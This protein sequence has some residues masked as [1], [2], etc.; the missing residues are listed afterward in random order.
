MRFTELPLAGAYLIEVEPRGDERGFFARV[1]CAR[2]FAAH[3]LS[4][5]WSQSNTSFSA[6]MGTVRGMH[7]QRPPHGEVKLVRCT[8]GAIF[9]AIVDMR[10]GSPTYGRWY[11]VRLDAE[12]RNMLYVPVGFAHGFQTLC[13]KTEVHY[14]VSSFYVPEAEGGLRH[15]DPEI[16][17]DWPEAVTVMSDRDRHHPD[18]L[19]QPAVDPSGAH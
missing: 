3:G 19:A 2:E 9:D 7:F 13:E 4:T 1:F 16:G 11:G 14:M 18:F 12:S 6:Q 8:S 5:D 10:A 17:I 15:D